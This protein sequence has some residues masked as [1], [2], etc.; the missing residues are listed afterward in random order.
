MTN[1]HN[2]TEGEFVP[3]DHWSGRVVFIALL[4]ASEALFGPGDGAAAIQTTL[5]GLLGVGAVFWIGLML[6]SRTAAIVSA[7]VSP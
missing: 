7:Y 6:H 4:A 1:A 3:G 2:M 5:C